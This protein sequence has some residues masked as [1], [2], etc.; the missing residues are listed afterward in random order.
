[1]RAVNLLPKDDAQR[2]RRQQNLPA[3]ISTGLIVLV[4]GLVGVLYFSAKSA[5]TTKELELQ[6]AKAELALLPTPS[7]LA[8]QTA[9]QRKLASERQ[10][11]I[12]ALSAA[13]GHRVAWDRVLREVSL[14]LPD[15]VWLTQ[16]AAFSPKPPTGSATATTA[17]GAVPQGFTMAGYTYS[18]DAVAR[19][20]TRLSVV[21]GLQNVWLER[22][23]RT[24][25]V[26]RYVITFTI[27]ADVRAPGAT[28]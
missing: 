25:L 15:D 18:H 28:S 24:K 16:L 10:A 20:L 6:D 23:L 14:V 9:G 11:R 4:T 2:G 1:V 26:G 19:L 27:R 3:L 13:L 5:S 12:A 17:P 22:S 7:E 8:S 21:P